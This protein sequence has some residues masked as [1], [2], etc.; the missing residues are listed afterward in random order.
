MNAYLYIQKYGVKQAKF[1]LPDAALYL[2]GLEQAIDDWLE[3][4]GWG[5]L[6]EL[7]CLVEGF[8][9]RYPN[10]PPDCAGIKMEQLIKRI[11]GGL[12]HEK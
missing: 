12:G 11:E 8:K 6:D 5:G 3:M 10:C 4:D 2:D 9:A 1:M 7:K